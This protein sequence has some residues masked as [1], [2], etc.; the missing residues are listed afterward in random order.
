MSSSAWLARPVGYQ[1]HPL[2]HCLVWDAHDFAELLARAVGQANVVPARLGHA[3]GAV[4]ADKDRK[5]QSDA[6]RL[7]GRF[8]ELGT[9]HDVEQLLGRAKL[10][11]SAQMHGVVA[12]QQSVKKPVQPDRIAVLHAAPVAVPGQE[13]LHRERGREF[14]DL[15]HGN[16]GQPVTVCSYLR[17]RGIEDREGLLGVAS[18]RLGYLGSRFAR[19]PCRPVAGVADHRG[20]RAHHHDHV[21]TEL[22][23]PSHCPQ[24][25]RVT[26]VQVRSGRVVPGVDPQRAVLVGGYRQT[27]SQ[28]FPHGCLKLGISELAAV[29]QHLGLRVEGPGHCSFWAF[30]ISSSQETAGSTT[31]P[32]ASR[33]AA[34]RGHGRDRSAAYRGGR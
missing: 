23:E 2:G 4:R 1:P 14:Q 6:G 13:L 28:P 34:A 29:H 12:L 21:M 8:L 10:H 33:L 20:H 17:P 18:R 3:V 22:L 25:D 19:T 9:G 7:P 5:R 32:E 26:Q 16:P 27:G 24:R 31:H 15:G 11:V 30:S